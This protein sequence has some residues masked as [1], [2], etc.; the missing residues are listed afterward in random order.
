MDST[1]ILIL[2][3]F[4]GALM[5]IAAPFILITL[6]AFIYVWTHSYPWLKMV[7]KWAA[8]PANFVALLTIFML[9][10]VII[11]ALVV[12]IHPIMLILLIPA[13]IILFP[14]DLAIIVWIVRVI[15]FIFT[16]L[17]GF[18]DAIFLAARLEFIKLKIKTDALKEGGTKGKLGALKSEFSSDARMVTGRVSRKKQSGFRGKLDALRG[19]FSSDIDKVRGRLSKRK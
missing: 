12:L 6:A 16:K 14:V 15:K 1:T 2:I 7:G 18:I 10:F 9:V 8:R 17:S 4:L 11:L 3:L 13:L 5:A 19:E